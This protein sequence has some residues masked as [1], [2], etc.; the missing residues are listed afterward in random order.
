M[1][2][3]YHFIFYLGSTICLLFLLAFVILDNM[4]QKFNDDSIDQYIFWEEDSANTNISDVSSYSLL[5]D[6]INYDN[7][8]NDSN[9][10]S[11]IEYDNDNNTSDINTDDNNQYTSNQDATSQIEK[12]SNKQ[13]SNKTKVSNSIININN[14]SHTE[15]TTLNGIGDV[16]ATRI[17]EY[18]NANGGFKSIDDI[19]NVSG[20]GDKK[21]DNIKARIT[22]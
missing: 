6:S 5:D 7:S 19:K 16:I 3:N 18:R 1:K 14:A 21:F 12:S 9:S 22:V 20:I 15:L 4:P 2:I 17:I 8:S 11:D 13:P 10:T